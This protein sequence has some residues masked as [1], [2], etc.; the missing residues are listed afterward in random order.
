MPF[1]MQGRGCCDVCGLSRRACRDSKVSQYCVELLNCAYS[2]V[3][4]HV[5]TSG[6]R[7]GRVNQ[8]TYQSRRTGCMCNLSES[9]CSEWER[10]DLTPPNDNK[11]SV[12]YIP[13]IHTTSS[14]AHHPPPDHPQNGGCE[15]A[16]LTLVRLLSTFVHAVH[17]HINS[18]TKLGAYTHTRSHT[19]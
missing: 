1:C 19:H 4:K 10:R 3:I 18:Q 12:Q 8:L 13:Q 17:N 2:L 7:L 16:T 11:T 5:Y 14:R 15:R 6:P 9:E